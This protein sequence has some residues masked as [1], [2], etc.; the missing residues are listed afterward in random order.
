MHCQ[1]PSD[2]WFLRL[3]LRTANVW[4]KTNV[5]VTQHILPR[6]LGHCVESRRQPAISFC[7]ALRRISRA[8]QG[9]YGG[10]I[11][12]LHTRCSAQNSS[13][14]AMEEEEKES[15][16]A[17][18]VVV[19]TRE[20][21]S[22]AFAPQFVRRRLSSASVHSVNSNACLTLTVELSPLL[23]V[24]LEVSCLHQGLL[25]EW[26]NASTFLGSPIP[27]SSPPCIRTTVSFNASGSYI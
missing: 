25:R 15:C 19:T 1:Y 4:S 6:F 9:L 27:F 3:R 14:K 8:M 10:G 11:I 22:M 21:K 24:K 20:H 26:C 23:P 17:C 2:T 12:L 16:A 18:A 13:R 5:A 7:G